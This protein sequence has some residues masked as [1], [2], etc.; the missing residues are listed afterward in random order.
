[1]VFGAFENLASRCKTSAYACLAV[2][3]EGRTN[4]RAK[5][6][7]KFEGSRGNNRGHVAAVDDVHAKYASEQ[8]Q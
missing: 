2:A 4:G 1:V 7:H 8:N 5:N 6:G 3:N